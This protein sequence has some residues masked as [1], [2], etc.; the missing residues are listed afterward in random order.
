MSK[1][2]R[3][4]L[5]AKRESWSRHTSRD[6]SRE[7]GRKGE[8]ERERSCFNFSCFLDLAFKTKW[9]TAVFASLD[10]KKMPCTLNNKLDILLILI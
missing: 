1:W 5:S 3:W 4:C 8:G 9:L 7:K 6:L 2:S 10:S